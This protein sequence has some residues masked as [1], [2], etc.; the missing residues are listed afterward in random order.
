MVPVGRFR[1]RGV[2]VDGDGP[3]GGAIGSREGEGM[4]QLETLLGQRL[5]PQPLRRGAASA[6][7]VFQ[8]V[9]RSPN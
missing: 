8:K 9:N 2:V 5:R 1:L 6:P 7:A 3:T 4:A